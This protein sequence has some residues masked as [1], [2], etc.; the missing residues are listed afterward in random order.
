MR[1]PLPVGVSF[2]GMLAVSATL[3]QTRAQVSMTVQAVNTIRAAAADPTGTVQ[4][5]ATAG[6]VGN[7]YLTA[8]TPSSSAT[9]W[10]MGEVFA[11]GAL[12]VWRSDVD[13]D[14]GAAASAQVS[15]GELLITLQAPVPTPIRIDAYR[16]LTLAGAGSQVPTLSMDVFDDG[17]IEHTQV[18][19]A[20]SSTPVLVGPQ[21]VTIRLTVDVQQVGVGSS[22]T[23]LDLLVYADNDLTFAPL[24]GACDGDEIRAG[25][26]FL[27]T[28]LLVRGTSLLPQAVVFGFSPVVPPVMLPPLASG[29]RCPLDVAPDVVLTLPANGAI[30]VPLPAAARPVSLW[31]QNAVLRPDGLAT[32]NSIR[33]DAN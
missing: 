8:A 25:S 19:P 3:S 22:S 23:S 18:G 29:T 17:V 14:T 26:S 6:S 30:E 28:G 5:S 1:K 24:T 13:V 15:S 33:V 31:I 12:L 20:T 4:Q 2:L 10:W 9:S 16:S 11:G 7:G 21:P 27:Q 32:T